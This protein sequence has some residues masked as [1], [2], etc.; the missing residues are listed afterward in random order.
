MRGS[1]AAEDAHAVRATHK[2]EGYAWGM[3][4]DQTVCTGCTACVVACV[5]E[6]NIPVIGKEQV[7]RGREM[8]WIRIDRYFEGDPEQPGHLPPADAVPALRERALRGGVPGGRDGAQQRRP[9]RHGL[10]PLRRHALLLEQLPV[11]GAALQLPALLRTGTRR[12]SS[13]SAIPTSRCGAAASWRSAPTACS[14]STRR[15]RT[16]RS[17]GRSDPRRRHRDR[18]PAGVPDRRDRLRQHQRSREPRRRSCKA[19]AHNYG[20]LADL[21][22]PAADDVSGRD[23]EPEPGAA[24]RDGP[25]RGTEAPRALPKVAAGRADSETQQHDARA[26]VGPSSLWLIVITP[27]WNR[28]PPRHPPGMARPQ[29]DVVGPGHSFGSVTDKITS[30][31]LRPG[32][33]PG[34]LVGFVIAFGVMSMFLFADHVAADQGHR[35]LGRQHPRRLGLRHR[36][37]RLVDRHRPRRHADLGDPAA[38]PAEVAHVDQPLR[39]G[40]DDL[41]R[42][43]RGDVPGLP[44]RPS[45][46]GGVLA[47]P[48]SEHAW[49]CGRTSAAR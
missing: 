23:Q 46:A 24:A 18:V 43:V 12:A 7:L 33:L 30:A 2:Y 42:H 3:A 41:R 49:A 45:V 29:S 6:N 10:Q 14:A 48:V 39:R 26:E 16:R 32:F 4:I 28:T 44:H 5:A 17:Q 1:A 9:E 11:Q 15:G 21:E 19:E 31:V 40:D 38:V 25:A 27:H 47:V 13:C 35:H 8:H 34:W 22:H 37:L 36:Q 20:V